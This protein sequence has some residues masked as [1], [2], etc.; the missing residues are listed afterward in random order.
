MASSGGGGRGEWIRT[1]DPLLPKQ[2]RYQAALRPEAGHSIPTGRKTGSVMVGAAWRRSGIAAAVGRR[3]RAAASAR[4]AHER[5][6]AVGDVPEG[7]TRD[8][9]ERRRVE[10]VGAVR[11]VIRR[12]VIR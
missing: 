4:S 2:M 3:S 6:A 1:T 10:T 8:M 9:A 12:I 5:S 11:V 7:V